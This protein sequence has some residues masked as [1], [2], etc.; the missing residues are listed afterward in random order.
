M[1]SLGP[2]EESGDFLLSR[3]A[4]QLTVCR[5]LLAPVVERTEFR[6][7]GLPTTDDIGSRGLQEPRCELKAAAGRRRRP[8]PLKQRRASEE[9]E[10]NGIRMVHD[11]D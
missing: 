4:C 1:R 5:Q 9:I 2:L 3:I 7:G 6:D 10:V 8:K 11:V